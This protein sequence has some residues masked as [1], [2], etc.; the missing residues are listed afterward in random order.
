M[1]RFR[2]L[3]KIGLSPCILSYSLRLPELDLILL[4][5]GNAAKTI[6]IEVLMKMMMTMMIMM[7][8]MILMFEQMR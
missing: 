7:I 2:G 8:M 3:G 5:H 1:R 4:E 6:E